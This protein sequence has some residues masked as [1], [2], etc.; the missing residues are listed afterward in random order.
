[1]E[2]A[3]NL[4]KSAML[5]APELAHPLPGAEISLTTDASDTHVGAVLT[6]HVRGMG[7]RLLAFF[8][9]KLDR[10]Q[11]RYSAFNRE[12]LACCLAVKHFRW[13][14]EGRSFCL[15]TDHKPLFCVTQGDRQLVCKAAEAFVIASRVYLGYLTLAGEGEYGC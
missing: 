15:F 6:Q 13:M 7:D 1:M 12:L 3:Y 4:S 5:N 14:L 2:Q 10:A 9:A 8:L 11:S